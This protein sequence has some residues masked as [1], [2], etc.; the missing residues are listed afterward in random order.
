MIGGVIHLAVER[1]GRNHIRQCQRHQKSGHSA[2]EGKHESLQQEL[3]QDVTALIGV[4]CWL[5]PSAFL[6]ATSSDCPGP[7]GLG[8]YRLADSFHHS[9]GRQMFM[10]V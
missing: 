4:C 7:L 8:A 1:H 6:Q 10:G 5:M 3:A 2:K 9:E